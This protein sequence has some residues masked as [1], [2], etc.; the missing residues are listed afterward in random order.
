MERASGMN[1]S[2]GNMKK[3]KVRKHGSPGKENE[4]GNLIG[5]GGGW[6]MLPPPSAHAKAGMNREH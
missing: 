5:S 6:Y 1:H 3:P 2:P 4:L